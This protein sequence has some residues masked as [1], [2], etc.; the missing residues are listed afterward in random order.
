MSDSGSGDGA[1]GGSGTSGT[2]QETALSFGR[3]ASDYVAGRPSYPLESVAWLL[4]DGS[5]DVVDVGAG[6][7][8][9]TETIVAA[10]HRVTAVEPDEVMLA[11]LAESLPGVVALSGTGEQLPLPDA[12]ADALV[13]GQAWHWVDSGRASAE[14]ARVLRPGGRLGLVWNLRDER[15]PWVAELTRVMGGSEA[16]RMI[17][18]DAVQVGEQFESAERHILAWTSTMT[19]E[20]IVRM[21]AS[22]SYVITAP[23]ERRRSVL[24]NVRQLLATHLGAI[25]RDPIGLPYRT[26]A[27]RAMLR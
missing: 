19:A 24:R 7:G 23:E 21:A 25:G 3:A 26:V 14:A 17:A 27:F 15:V 20:Q 10:G 9:L 8:K 12:S 6:T 11:T 2:A 16:E 5:L 13:Y 22:R 1:A 18:D 4:G